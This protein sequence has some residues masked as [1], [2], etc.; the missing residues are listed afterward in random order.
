MKMRVLGCQ[1]RRRKDP[2]NSAYS[3]GKT[4]RAG[5][6]FQDLP[7]AIVA[8]CLQHRCNTG[9]KKRRSRA[10]H[11]LF[12]RLNLLRRSEQEQVPC[13]PARMCL[14]DGMRVCAGR[15]CI[16]ARNL[17]LPYFLGCSI[18]RPC[19]IL[20]R[21]CRNAVTRAKRSRLAADPN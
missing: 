3:R 13:H 17:L 16:W 10:L 2:C 1:P 18:R 9:R 20:R 12:D 4:I 5:T 21:G 15:E 8:D 14:S 6:D 11:F 7:P 19:S